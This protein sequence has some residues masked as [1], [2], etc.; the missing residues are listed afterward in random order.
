MTTGLKEAIL[1]FFCL[2]I[3]W[4]GLGRAPMPGR[5]GRASMPGHWQ[6]KSVL[7]SSPHT[8]TQNALWRDIVPWRID[9]ILP[10]LGSS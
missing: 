9:V 5:R 2:G 8:R 1:D 10:F 6:K 4:R 3:P 7:Q